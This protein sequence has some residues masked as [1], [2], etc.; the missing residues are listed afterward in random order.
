MN[1]LL[2]M[3]AGSMI[4]VIEKWK[5]RDT[6]NKIEYVCFMTEDGKQYM[7]HEDGWRR[8]IKEIDSSHDAYRLKRI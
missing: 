7:V 1:V 2:S 5:W 4:K 3:E 6:K 8:I